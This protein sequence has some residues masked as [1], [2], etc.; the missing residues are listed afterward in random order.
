MFQAGYLGKDCFGTG[1]NFDIFV[2]RGAGA[3]I[4]GEE[5]VSL[6]I[7]QFLQRIPC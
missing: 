6:S 3:Y 7:A 2:H 1:Y 5:T 4:C